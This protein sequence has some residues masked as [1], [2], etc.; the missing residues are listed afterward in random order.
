MATYHKNRLAS[1]SFKRDAKKATSRGM[2][3][4]AKK[5]CNEK[6]TDSMTLVNKSKNL[7]GIDGWLFS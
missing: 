4:A 6:Y 5:S 1:L 7:Y 2:R 3:R